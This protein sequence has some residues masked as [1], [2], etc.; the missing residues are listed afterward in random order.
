MLLPIKLQGMLKPLI[1]P[2]HIENRSGDSQ[3]YYEFTIYFLDRNLP[4][5]KSQ[6]PHIVKKEKKHSKI[7]IKNSFLAQDTITGDKVIIQV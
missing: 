5:M 7:Q 6:N 4:N 2:C 1:F 3:E